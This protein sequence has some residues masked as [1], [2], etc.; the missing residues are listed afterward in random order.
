MPCEA[1][2]FVPAEYMAYNRIWLVQSHNWARSG[3]YRGLIAKKK[4]IAE[5]HDFGDIKIVLFG[6]DS[7]TK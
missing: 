3:V 2:L 5:D 6:P 7:H 4:K 1:P